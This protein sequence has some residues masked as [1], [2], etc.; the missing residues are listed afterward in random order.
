MSYLHNHDV[1][2]QYEKYEGTF[3]LDT[4]FDN[5]FDANVI[6]IDAIITGPDQN[7]I[8]VPAFIS[9]H[10]QVT[11]TVPEDY[12]NPRHWVW[13]I[14]FAPGVPG[15][16]QV[17]LRAI[18]D[19][20]IVTE[21]G[22]VASFSCE[23]SEG[24]GMIRCDPN[25]VHCLQYDDGSPRTNIGHNVCWTGDGL[26]GF[27]NYYAGLQRGGENWTRLWMTNF[28][29]GTILEWNANSSGYF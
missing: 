5:P 15:D 11:E 23:A 12:V 2:G 16:Y 14:R 7:E 10:Y 13:K 17:S 18:E 24:Q 9:R 6:A 28:Y 22:T 27:K 25:D 29:N 26:P 1:L 8:Q 20:S 21:L 19:D 4:E 3:Q